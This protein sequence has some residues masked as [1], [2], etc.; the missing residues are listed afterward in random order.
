[1]DRVST[2]C[3]RCLYAPRVLLTENRKPTQRLTLWLTESVVSKACFNNIEGAEKL[4]SAM[5]RTDRALVMRP[6]GCRVRPGS[7]VIFRWSGF[8]YD[9]AASVSWTKWHICLRPCGP[10]G[11]RNRLHVRN[12]CVDKSSKLRSQHSFSTPERKTR[13]SCVPY[14][15]LCS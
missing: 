12:G 3:Y 7:Y 6:S 14:T 11:M 13:E 2:F 10:C 9:F 5:T 8:L 4:S 1:M 15:A